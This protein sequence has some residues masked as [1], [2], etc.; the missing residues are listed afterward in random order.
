MHI[1]CSW[2]N[3]EFKQRPSPSSSLTSSSSSSS[4]SPTLF[5]QQKQLCPQRICLCAVEVAPSQYLCILEF[6]LLF[7]WCRKKK[8]KSYVKTDDNDDDGDGGHND[9]VSL[10]I[11]LCNNSSLAAREYYKDTY[12]FLF[13]DFS[14]QPFEQQQHSSLLC[15]FFVFL[16]TCIFDCSYFQIFHTHTHH[17][18]STTIMVRKWFSRMGC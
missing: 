12:W 11:S 8:L 5:T 7:W 4:L 1:L 15:I 14:L 18:T 17:H 10:S 9:E 2:I 3:K 6:P 16:L 13:V